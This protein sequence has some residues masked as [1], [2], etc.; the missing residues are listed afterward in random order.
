MS[1]KALAEQTLARLAAD[2]ASPETTRETVTKQ[3]KQLTRRGETSGVPCFSPL[4]Q[5]LPQKTA[6]FR[7]CFTVSFPRDGTDETSPAVA[8]WREHLDRLDPEFPPDAIQPCRW[9]QMIDDAGRF[10]R[11]WGEQAAGFG[12]S[13]LDLFGVSPGFARRL[14]RDGLL[15]ALEGRVVLAMTADAATIDSRGGKSTRHYRR[16]RPGAVPWWQA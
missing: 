13:D 16:D 2:A 15:Y 11:V 9:W 1:L 14:D 5:D 6:I 3:A 7:H 8:S 12:W 4:K 10:L